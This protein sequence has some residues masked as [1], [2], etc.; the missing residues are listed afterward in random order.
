MLKELVAGA[1]VLAWAGAAQAETTVIH[2]G[3]LIVDAAKP[4]HGPSTITVTDGHIAA[5]AGGFVSAPA[6]AKVVELKDKTVLPGL[7]DVHVHL[8]GDP[9][10][11][12]WEEAVVTPEY[13]VAVGLKNAR[14]TLA[15]GFTTVR[16][17]GAAPQTIFAVRD[18]IDKGLF[19][20]PRIVAAGSPISIIGGHGDVSGFRPEVLHALDGHNT[21]TGAVECAARVREASRAGS[22]VIKIMATGG[23]L[24][25]QGRG[26]GAHFTAKEM[27]AIADTAHSLGLKVAAHAHGARGIE[28]AAE[29]G[30]DSIEHGTFIDADGVKTM[31]AHRTWFVP[32]LMAYTGIRERLGKHI[33]TPTVEAK[34]RQTL[35]YVGKGLQAAYKAGVRVAFGTDA[36]VY[37]HGRNNQEAVEMVERGGMSP[38]DVLVAATSGAAELLG[39]ADETGTLEVGKAADLIAVSGDPQADAHALLK[40]DYVMARGKALD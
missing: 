8:T 7:I 22:D 17:L 26:L 25:Q 1:V 12:Y 38:K 32:T 31:K 19:A 36:G 6:G 35:D 11:P 33:Y 10:T 34:V 30:I 39:I 40:V 29:A 27:E 23:V 14:V 13:G 28:A 15:S 5:I 9:G 21:C 24:S 37:E 16:D 20:G 3:R 2:A 18:A 4:A